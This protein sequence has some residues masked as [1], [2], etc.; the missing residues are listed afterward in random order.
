[1]VNF[2]GLQKTA[3]MV[4]ISVN[5]LRKGVRDGLFPFTRN[6]NRYLLSPEQIRA[7]LER[8]ALS[9]QRSKGG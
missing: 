6:G 5:A 3:Q 2:H 1:M 4:G 9:N 8:E 7:T